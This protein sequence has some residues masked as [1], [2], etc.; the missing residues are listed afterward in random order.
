MKK[1]AGS[2]RGGRGSVGG[3]EAENKS[4]NV[5]KLVSDCQLQQDVAAA[6]ACGKHPRQ[7]ATGQAKRPE[8][9]SSFRMLNWEWKRAIWR[10]TG[11][12]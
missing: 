6:A 7:L 5:A 1:Y 3:S 11:C 10:Y 8:N 4:A 2:V 12:F 9:R